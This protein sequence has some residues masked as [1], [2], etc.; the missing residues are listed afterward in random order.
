LHYILDIK[1][2][3]TLAFKVTRKYFIIVTFKLL[4]GKT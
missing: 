4:G 1:K 2:R 3:V